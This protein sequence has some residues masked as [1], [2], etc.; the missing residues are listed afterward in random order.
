VS[1]T[2]IR[3]RNCGICLPVITTALFL[4]LDSKGGL[5]AAAFLG[6]LVFWVML[7]NQFHKWSHQE[8][9][10]GAVRFLQRF[11]L[12]L[13]PA[14]HAVH[15]TAPF[16]RCYG[17]TTGWLNPLLGAVGFYPGLE[18]L[19]TRLTGALPRKEDLGEERARQVA[20][21]MAD[22]PPVRLESSRSTSS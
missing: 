22:K 6:A 16:N 18:R 9:P 20:Q 17:I 2:S 15:H 3:W 10:A 21:A 11:H 5:F 13:P 19:V 1:T 14:H 4:P 8:H 7:T 12:I